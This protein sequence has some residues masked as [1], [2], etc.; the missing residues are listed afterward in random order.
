MNTTIS[1][2]P[3]PALPFIDEEPIAVLNLPSGKARW[4][5]FV[6]IACAGMLVA[7][8]IESGGAAAFVRTILIGLA[9]LAGLSSNWS[10]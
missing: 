3:A 5:L 6:L 1:Q 10:A 4:A 8:A 2:Q 9:V 7:G